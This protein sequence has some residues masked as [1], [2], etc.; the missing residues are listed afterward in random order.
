MIILGAILLGI[1]IG[2]KVSIFF[3]VAG[4]KKNEKYI[5]K[6]YGRKLLMTC[7]EIDEV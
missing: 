1:I 5:L 2:Y 4:L 3:F 7:K 6:F